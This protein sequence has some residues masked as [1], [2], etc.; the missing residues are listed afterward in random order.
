[1]IPTKEMT[2][3]LKDASKKTGLPVSS[4]MRICIERALN[5]I[6]EAITKKN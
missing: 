2:K 1:M 5:D 6:V 3:K 4:L